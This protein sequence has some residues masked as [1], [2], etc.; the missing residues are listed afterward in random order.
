MMERYRGDRYGDYSTTSYGPT[1]DDRNHHLYHEGDDRHHYQH[2]GRHYNNRHHD[3]DYLH[4]NFNGEE[5]YPTSGHHDSNLHLSG[6]K[7]PLSQSDFVDYGGFVKLFVGAVP[8][9]TTEQDIHSVF[10]E[11]GHI[12]EV[13]LLKDKRTGVQQE[14]CFVK[15]ST[16]EAAERAIVVLNGHY[17]FPGGMIPIKV[18]YADGEHERLGSFGSAVHKL[19]VGCVNK[20]ASKREIEE[21]FSSFGAIEDIYVVRDEFKQ[22]RGC[23]FIQFSCRDMAIAAITALHGR[24]VMRG[25]DQPLI[26]RF[27]DPKKPR[28]GDS[29]PSPYLNDQFSGH[30]PPNDIRPVESPQ[31]GC[32]PPAVSSTCSASAAHE[33]NS[34]TDMAHSIDC[35]WSEH[36]CPDGHLYYYNCV[37]CESR[38]EK[39]EEYAHYEQELEKL[40]EQLQQQQESKLQILSSPEVSQTQ[41]V[42]HKPQLSSQIPHQPMSSAMELNHVHEQATTFP[43]VEPAIM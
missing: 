39:P 4:P 36:V 31:I 9:T 30:M 29:R 14:C 21:I 37:T 42:Q 2:H 17:T 26:V 19:Y 23:A 33:T 1:Y 38:W 40:E 25:C 18:K 7:R 3:V 32:K 35:D 16:V 34:S 13:I 5:N 12:V 22:N 27:A 6:H 8:R 43:V 41:P 11:Y 28:A 10:G 15:Y 20:Q 24:Y